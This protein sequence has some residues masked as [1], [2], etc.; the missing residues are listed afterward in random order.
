[1]GRRA[2]DAG[3]ARRIAFGADRRPT[4]FER[5]GELL[6][7]RAPLVARRRDA[8][9]R[10]R[11]TSRTRWR[12]RRRA[13]RAASTL[14][15]CGRASAH[16]AGVAHRLEEV[17]ELD[18]V[19]YVNDSKATNVASTL[20][21]LEA[22]AERPRPPDPRRQGKGQDFTALREPLAERCAGVYLIG[23]DAMTIATALANIAPDVLEC[24]DL[25]RALMAAVRGGERS[26]AAGR[27]GEGGQSCCSRRPARAS[28]SSP[29]SRPAAS[30]FASWSKNCR[31]SF[32]GSEVS[33]NAICRGTARRSSRGSSIH[34]RGQA[35][36][37]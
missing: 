11:T 27:P 4:L 36:S 22:F 33:S 5:A 26:G 30:A 6:V 31:V 8:P 1:M 9:A 7:A 37:G 29:T 23:E 24:G 19:L 12:P 18:G 34:A 13:W 2:C 17:A 35:R 14:R 21:A 25:E 28:T 3:R 20:V 16:F 32:A 10:A 15:R